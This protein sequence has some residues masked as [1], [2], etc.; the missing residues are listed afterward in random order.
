MLKI[1]IIESATNHVSNN[2]QPAKEN[3]KNK[4]KENTQKR[5]FIKNITRLKNR[6]I[7]VIGIV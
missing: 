1:Q 2:A 3:N 5:E 7:K 6:Y 4:N